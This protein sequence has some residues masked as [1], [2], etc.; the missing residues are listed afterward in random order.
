MPQEVRVGARAA[1]K[2]L[3]KRDP[4]TPAND[5]FGLLF[6]HNDY[7]PAPGWVNGTTTWNDFSAETPIGDWIHVAVVTNT[8]GTETTSANAVALAHELYL[9][10]SKA[11]IYVN[12]HKFGT[13]PND[14]I[15]LF[16]NADVIGDAPGDATYTPRP[17]PVR[18][19]NATRFQVENITGSIKIDELTFWNSDLTNGGT[20]AGTNP[21]VF[22]DGKTP[23]AG[24]ADWS[25]F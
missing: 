23:A 7:V 21:A 16:N 11:W 15:D 25:V 17:R 6:S 22:G 2:I 4:I 24:V 14:F 9:P 10:G 8:A 18:A 19:H 1:A 12:G 3:I 5:R 20:I 13:S